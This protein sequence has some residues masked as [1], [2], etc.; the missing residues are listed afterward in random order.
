M[1]STIYFYQIPDMT[2]LLKEMYSETEVQGL[3]AAETI[4]IRRM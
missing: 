3:T 4:S 2:R 1:S